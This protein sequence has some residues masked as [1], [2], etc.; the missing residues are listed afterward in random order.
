[1]T[2]AEADAQR[3]VQQARAEER[4]EV[5]A[6]AAE[7]VEAVD[8]HQTA[9]RDASNAQAEADRLR[10]RADRLTDDNGPS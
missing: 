2:R 8:D 9:V 5:G 3:Q 10:A 1:M 7:F 4:E 6:A